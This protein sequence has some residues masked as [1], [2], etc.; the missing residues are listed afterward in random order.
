VLLILVALGAL[1]LAPMVRTEVLP[2]VLPSGV[3]RPYPTDRVFRGFE[4]CRGRGRHH[5]E[6]I[7]LG[8]VGPEGGL[9]TAIRSMGP[10][11]ITRIGRGAV[12]PRHFGAP[13][14]R[15]GRARRGRR[16]FPRKADIGGYGEV[17]FFS[18]RAG[19]WRSGDLIELIGT[20]G[21]LKDHRIRYMHF[22]EIRPDLEVGDLVALGE[23]LGLLGGTGVMRSSPHV[24]IDIVDPEGRPVD[25][26]PLLGL[27]PTARCGTVAEAAKALYEAQDRSDPRWHY[28][29][30]APPVGSPPRSPRQGPSE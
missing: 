6:A 13:D 9:G 5:H 3:S 24:H 17:S 10:A 25:V 27:P 18:L 15:P 11:R 1:E 7:D 22:A 19:K 8:G 30:W 2:Q 20:D 14:L 29:E 4:Y 26:A 23:E 12:D 16:T 28:A 21:P